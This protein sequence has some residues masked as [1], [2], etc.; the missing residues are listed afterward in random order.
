VHKA[1]NDLL[2]ILE[3]AEPGQSKVILYDAHGKPIQAPKAPVNPQISLEE[4]KILQKNINGQ[5]YDKNSS[6]NLKRSLHN[7]SQTLNEFIEKAGSPEH[8]SAWKEAE[9]LTKQIKQLEKDRKGWL[10]DK[11][12]ELREAKSA[13]RSSKTKLERELKQ[14]GK[15]PEAFLQKQVQKQAPG[16]L[17]E[18]FNRSTGGGLGLLGGAIAGGVPGAALTSLGSGALKNLANR[19]KI[20]QYVAQFYP[21]LYQQGRPSGAREFIKGLPLA[22]R[23]GTAR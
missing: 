5:I 12:T 2:H 3:G 16:S 11:R 10:S 20:N 8:R 7:L 15:N 21:E 18:E 17:L 4:A 14:M 1:S 13:A 23:I 9:G 6:P 19:N 22:T